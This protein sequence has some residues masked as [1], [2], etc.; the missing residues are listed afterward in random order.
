MPRQLPIVVNRKLRDDAVVIILGHMFYPEDKPSAEQF[1]HL[2]T[3]EFLAHS[4]VPSELFRVVTKSLKL[5]KLPLVGEVALLLAATMDGDHSLSLSKAAF[6]VSEHHSTD[7]DENGKRIPT[8]ENKIRETFAEYSSVAHLWAAFQLDRLSQTE[9]SLIDFLAIAKLIQSKIN[10]R[11]AQQKHE[12]WEI[13]N[14]LGQKIGQS[15]EAG[16]IENCQEI[17]RLLESYASRGGRT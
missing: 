9:S 12:V 8:S 11:N 15:P 10:E 3:R 13:P 6:V 4:D 5:G 7:T 17:E 2:T 14:F 1:S 16:L